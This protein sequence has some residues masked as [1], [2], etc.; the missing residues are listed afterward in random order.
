[1]PRPQGKQGLAMVLALL[2][3]QPYPL[4]AAAEAPS[5]SAAVL[6]SLS[7]YGP[8]Q[9]G[10]IAA[11]AE[12]T[13]FDG[14]LVS[15]LAGRA[16][17]QYQTGARV[18]VDPN[19]AAQ[20]SAGQVQLQRGQMDFLSSA[21]NAPVFLASTLRLEPV[22]PGSS[23]SVSLN[24]GKASVAVIKG[25]I[26]VV[27][28]TGARLRS[29]E[30]GQSALFAIASAPA[31]PASPSASPAQFAPGTTLWVLLAAGAAAGAATAVLLLKG[32]EANPPPL[33]VSRP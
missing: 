23:A 6:G 28:P 17:V 32:S 8:V 19:S 5:A 22:Q 18:V 11:P 12:T 24:E 33:S 4:Q 16:V 3:V 1:V 31:A 9:V 30:V 7:S 21:E 2:M 25:A 20:F 13:L 27:D 14:D 29:L 10:E 26:R 15:T